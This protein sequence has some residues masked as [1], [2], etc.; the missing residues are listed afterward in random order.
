[1]EELFD[2]YPCLS[3]FNEGSIFGAEQA[4]DL[5]DSFFGWERTSGEPGSP[6]QNKEN[7]NS[8]K[9]DDSENTRRKNRKDD[10]DYESY[11]NEELQRHKLDNLNPSVQKKMIQKIRNRM[12]A[13]RSRQRQ[14]NVLENLEN[15]NL[16]LRMANVELC[17]QLKELQSENIDLKVTLQKLQDSKGSLSTSQEIED[18]SF[19]SEGELARSENQSR[20][21][22]YKG[23]LFLA[24]AAIACTMAPS[25][26]PSQPSIVMMGGVVPMVGRNLSKKLTTGSQLKTL[27]DQCKPYCPKCKVHSDCPSQTAGRSLKIYEEEKHRIQIALNLETDTWM[28][29]DPKVSYVKSQALRIVINRDALDSIDRNAL[30]FADIQKIIF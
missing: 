24:I 22:K 16:N 17:R 13:Q 10:F 25:S 7:K 2:E 12:S 19:T 28:C 5:S 8:F 3:N 21:L 26:E 29:F 6:V 27:E 4:D 11:I 20:S 30:Y 1:M 9:T 23:L 15:E 14:K 18:Q